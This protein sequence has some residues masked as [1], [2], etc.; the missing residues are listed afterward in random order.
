M[1]GEILIFQTKGQV[2][3]FGFGSRTGHLRMRP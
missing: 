2:S 1:L 3:V